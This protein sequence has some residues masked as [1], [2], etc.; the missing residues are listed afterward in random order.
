MRE[1]DVQ[2]TNNTESSCAVVDQINSPTVSNG[3]GTEGV[4]KGGRRFKTQ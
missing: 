1:V 4:D 2:K 3:L